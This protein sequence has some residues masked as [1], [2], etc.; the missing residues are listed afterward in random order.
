MCRAATLSV[1]CWTPPT[2]ADATRV[3]MRVVTVR[4]VTVRVVTV[5]PA[6]PKITAV[7]EL[8]LV[9]HGLHSGIFGRGPHNLWLLL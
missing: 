2:L 5:T 7:A 3:A 6:V 1:P 4:V 9:L 8:S